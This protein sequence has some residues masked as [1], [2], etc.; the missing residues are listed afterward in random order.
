MEGNDVLVYE[1]AIIKETLTDELLLDYVTIDKV[2]LWKTTDTE[3]KYWTMI[4]FHSD[5]DD[6]PERL[7]ETIIDG[8]WFADLK[9]GNRKYIIFKN[10]VLQYEIGNAAE[11]EAVLDACRLRGIPDSQFN[12]SE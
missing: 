3:I 9:Q 6:F 4:F 5:T 10:K 8:G 2:D 7:A 1:G 12:W 11:K